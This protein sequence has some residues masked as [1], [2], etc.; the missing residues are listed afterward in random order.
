MSS[1]DKKAFFQEFKAIMSIYA[2]EISISNQ[3]T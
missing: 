2:G 3:P 1:T